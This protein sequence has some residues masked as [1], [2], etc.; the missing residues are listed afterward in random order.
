MFFNKAD[1]KRVFKAEMQSLIEL[2]NLDN[3][4]AISDAEDRMVKRITARINTT[5]AEAIEMQVDHFWN[6][7]EPTFERRIDKYLDNKAK[8]IDQRIHEAKRNMQDNHSAFIKE[9]VKVATEKITTDQDVI[10]NLVAQ[11]NK[12]QLNKG[13]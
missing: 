10:S 12:L 11:L 2:A 6:G 7:V 9:V 3:A 1:A 13:D 4:R 5:V 8:Y